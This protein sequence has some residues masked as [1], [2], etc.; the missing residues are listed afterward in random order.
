M[1]E[2]VV[3]N[4]RVVLTDAPGFD[5]TERSDIEILENI[6]EVTRGSYE[7][8][9]LLTGVTPIQ[10]VTRHEIQRNKNRRL[11]LFKKIR[12][13]QA[14][15]HTVVATTLWSGLS[16]EAEDESRVKQH[17]RRFWH[18]MIAGGAQVVRHGNN[19]AFA[20]RIIRILINKGQVAL[21]ML[22]RLEGVVEN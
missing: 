2:I 21:Q 17:K 14:C 8:G 20:V 4:K 6:A 5:D 11:W 15:S 22:G 3:D 9:P 13:E 1:V 16:N 10:T 18:D 19:A 12:G 7:S